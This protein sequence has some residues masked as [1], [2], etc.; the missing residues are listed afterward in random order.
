MR[1]CIVTYYWRCGM[2]ASLLGA[3]CTC[4]SGHLRLISPPTYRDVHTAAS[5]PLWY[6]PVNRCRPRESRV[7]WRHDCST[8]AAIAY[9]PALRH[10]R[11]ISRPLYIDRSQRRSLDWVSDTRYRGEL[12]SSWGRI[13]CILL[14][15]GAIGHFRLNV[16]YLRYDPDRWFACKAINGCILRIARMLIKFSCLLTWSGTSSSVAGISSKLIVLHLWALLWLHGCPFPP[17]KT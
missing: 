4:E 9:L 3:P 12:W 17:Y 6:R 5:S 16:Q 13:R 15:G 14:V 10:S 11:Q 1:V 7:L 8:N 2:T